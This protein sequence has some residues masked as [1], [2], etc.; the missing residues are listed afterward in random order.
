MGS[1]E[2]IFNGNYYLSELYNVNEE[3]DK[4]LIYYKN[5]MAAKDSLFNE[6]RDQ[7][8]TRREMN[9]EF[10][11]KENMANQEY[12]KSLAIQQEKQKNQRNLSLITIVFLLVV[13]TVVLLL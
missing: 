6:K 4:A 9:Y 5:A 13:G 3:Y 11:K 12:N 10:E 1:F 7:R 2:D 8:I